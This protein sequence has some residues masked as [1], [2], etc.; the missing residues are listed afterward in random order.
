MVKRKAVAPTIVAWQPVTL[1]L[2]VF[3]QPPYEGAEE[4]WK[5]TVGSPAEKVVTQAKT[6]ERTEEGTFLQGKLT[7]EINPIRIDWRYSVIEEVS[8]PGPRINTL[9]SFSENYDP[10]R[11]LMGKWLSIASIPRITR[12]AFGAVMLQLTE[13]M[14]KGYE[15]LTP[16]L[17]F[18]NLRNASDLQYQINRTRSSQSRI[19]DLEINRLSKWAVLRLQQVVVPLGSPNQMHQIVG[20]FASYLE[21]DISTSAT[22]KQPLPK[23]RLS[24]LFTELVELG[25][26]IAEKGDIE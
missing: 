17:P 15:I 20:D 19:P 6:Q 21:V 11:V 23:V 10:F 9:G 25:A 24:T 14:E 22:Y 16:Y 4:W 2:T 12:L 13:T 7:L 26:E 5:A 3:T 18:L 8:E 1:R